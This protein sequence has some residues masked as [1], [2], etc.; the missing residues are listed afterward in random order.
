M[1]NLGRWLDAHIWGISGT[2]GGHLG[3]KRAQKRPLRILQKYHFLNLDDWRM[4]L[5]RTLQI[6][7][8]RTLWVHP[9]KEAYL[10]SFSYIAIMGNMVFL[11]LPR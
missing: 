6:G 5:D 2:G 10:S 9:P 1:G 8:K 7:L 11:D 4:V 3:P